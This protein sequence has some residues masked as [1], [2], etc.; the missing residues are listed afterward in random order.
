HSG[1][2]VNGL[3]GVFKPKQKPWID[4]EG[5]TTSEI[6]AQVKKCPSGAL[7]YYLK[8]D[9]TKAKQDMENTKTKVQVM[10]N[11]PLMVTGGVIVE[12]RDGTTETKK[13]AAFCR[14]G[15]S[16]NKPFCD[17]AHSKQGFIG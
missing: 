5:A 6:I 10:E 14:C 1:I 3:P 17:G 8:G 4:M 15:H 9:E 13:N 11:G 2:C 12:H 16:A 7:S